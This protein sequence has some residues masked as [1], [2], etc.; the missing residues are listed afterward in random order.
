MVLWCW[1]LFVFFVNFMLFV[2]RLKVFS[3]WI[4]PAVSRPVTWK[5]QHW[6]REVH[7]LHS[8]SRLQHVSSGAIQ[9]FQKFQ[10]PI[11]AFLRI[12]QIAWFAWCFVSCF[13]LFFFICRRSRVVIRFCR[14]T[15][16]KELRRWRFQADDVCVVF[17][18]R[19]AFRFSGCK[20]NPPNPSHPWNPHIYHVKHHFKS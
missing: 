8:P 13:I 15:P 7:S 4:P 14:P 18:R 6:K 3:T 19:K 10:T 2:F 20:T 1:K 16:G 9:T 17:G 5:Q 12:V 11:F